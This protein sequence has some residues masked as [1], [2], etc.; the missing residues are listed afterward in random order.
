MLRIVT[1]LWRAPTQWHGHTYSEKEVNTLFRMIRRNTTIPWEPVCITDD[2]S[3]IDQHTRIVP[4]WDDLRDWGR[5]WT[6]LKLYSSEMR[7]IIGSRFMMLDLDTVIVSN[8]DHLLTRMEPF[9]GFACPVPPGGRPAAIYNGGMVTMDA[10]SRSRIWETLPPSPPETSFNGSD[11][12]WVSHVLGK[13]EATYGPAD[14]V[15]SRWDYNEQPDACMV[16]LTG[17]ADPRIEPWSKTDWIQR[18][19]R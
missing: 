6:R 8:M 14:G 17:S 3:G 4:L 2:P 9:I 15:Y 1:F 5:C 13:G 7:T 18:H 10:G 12:A 19:Y 11:Q 16:H